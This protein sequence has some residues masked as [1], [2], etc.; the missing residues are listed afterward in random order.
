MR[1]KLRFLWKELQRVG[2]PT[3]AASLLSLPMSAQSTPEAF[4]QMLQGL[5]RHSLPVL[6]PAALSP[7][8]LPYLLLDTRAPDEY[9]VSH[10]PG[11]RWV[12]YDRF[13][14]DCVADLAPARPILVYC[15]VGYRSERIGERLRALGFTQ[16]YNLY[17]GIFAWLHAGY[18]LR[19]AEGQPTTRVHTYNR[20]WSQWLRAGEAVY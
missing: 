13:D 12:G 19:D 8:S 1:G 3:L 9:A 4:D 5:L 6:R 11:A 18:P 16:V 2:L 17:G 10:L 14:P 20:K 7:D 15:S